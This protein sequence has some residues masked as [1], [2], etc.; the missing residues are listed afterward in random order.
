MPHLK[1]R[2]L[3]SRKI[4]KEVTFKK[5]ALRKRRAGRMLTPKEKRA[6]KRSRLQLIAIG[7][8]K[9]RVI[10]PSIPMRMGRVR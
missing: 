5:Q 3:I 8:S 4:R 10:D 1:Q 6:I 2:A 9:A 7:F